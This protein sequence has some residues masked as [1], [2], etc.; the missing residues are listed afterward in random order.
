MDPTILSRDNNPFDGGQ[1]VQRNPFMQDKQAGLILDAMPLDISIGGGKKPSSKKNLFTA[2]GGTK[3]EQVSSLERYRLEMAAATKKKGQECDSNKGSYLKKIGA[4]LISHSA[5]GSRSC[6]ERKSSYDDLRSR[7]LHGRR[8]LHER[9]CLVTGE[10][11]EQSLLSSDFC[12][13]EIQ[14]LGHDS[15]ELTGRFSSHGSN[16]SRVKKTNSKLIFRR[17]E[18]YFVCPSCQTHV[19][20]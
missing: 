5:H 9:N 12:E 17:N 2:L 14:E 6:H 4:S 18:T 16:H 7:S 20:W 11:D 3:K 19:L 10:E 1:Y 15:A 8:S 13:D